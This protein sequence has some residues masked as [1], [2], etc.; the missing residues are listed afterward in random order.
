MRE[1]RYRVTQGAYSGT[2]GDCIGRWYIDD[3]RSSNI[4]RRGPGYR[5]KREAEKAAREIAAEGEKLKREDEE[6]GRE[7]VAYWQEV[8]GLYN[9]KHEGG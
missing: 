2:S 1:Q 5:T 6:E 3:T 8:E 9:S 7:W 4:D